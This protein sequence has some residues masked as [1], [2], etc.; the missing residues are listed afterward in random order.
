MSR[1]LKPARYVRL[2][3]L[4]SWVSGLSFLV[5]TIDSHPER[6][7]PRPVPRGQR[8]ATSER[9]P[10]TGDWRPETGDRR[11]ETGDWK[12]GDWKTLNGPADGLCEIFVSGRTSV[13]E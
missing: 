2:G 11:L 3:G 6:Q 8:S 9:R 1:R 5:M 13:D 4:S 7:A 10:E 12:T